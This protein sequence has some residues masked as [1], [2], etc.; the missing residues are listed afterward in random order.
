MIPKQNSKLLVQGL[1]LILYCISVIACIYWT[2]A[3]EW[4]N[5]SL[6]LPLAHSHTFARLSCFQRSWKLHRAAL[7]SSSLPFYIFFISLLVSY[8]L[9]NCLGE[10]LKRDNGT[11]ILET[12]KRLLFSCAFLL[13]SH[14]YNFLKGVSWGSFYSF[15]HSCYKVEGRRGRNDLG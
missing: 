4:E 8:C 15:E 3:A 7:L 9:N 2:V 10:I 1:C 11:N 6:I 5:V 14:W 13:S 12:W